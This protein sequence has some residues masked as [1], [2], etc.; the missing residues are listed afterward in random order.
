MTDLDE[1]GALRLQALPVELEKVRDLEEFDGPLLSEFR[2]K[3]GEVFPLLNGVT[4]M[5]QLIDGLCYVRHLKFSLSILP[6]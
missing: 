2:S 3:E 1:I 6:E 5:R 4:A